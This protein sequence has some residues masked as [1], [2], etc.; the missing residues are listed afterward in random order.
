MKLQLEEHEKGWKMSLKKCEDC[1]TE[2]SGNP[3]DYLCNCML[4]RL[5]ICWTSIEEELPPTEQDIVV[6]GGNRRAVRWY[7]RNGN[8]TFD[9]GREKWTHWMPLLSLP[10]QE[11]KS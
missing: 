1:G 6:A 3:G 10:E 2:Y 9:I 5:M 7:D 11:E 4:E 8:M